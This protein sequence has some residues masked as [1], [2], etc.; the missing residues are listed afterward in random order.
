MRNPRF[1]VMAELDG[2]RRLTPATVVVHR[3]A[4]TLSVRPYRR[5]RTYELPLAEVAAIVY[6]RIIRAEVAAKRAARRKG[7]RA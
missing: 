5:R 1:R 2:R 7:G 6:Q 4:L 3:G